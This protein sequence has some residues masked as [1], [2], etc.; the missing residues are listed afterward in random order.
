MAYSEDSVAKLAHNPLLKKGN[1]L[2][3]ID[4]ST[5]S[6]VDI[7]PAY[8]DIELGRMYDYI[9]FDDEAMIARMREEDMNDSDIAAHTFRFSAEDI[10]SAGGHHY[11][12]YRF[13]EKQVVLHPATDI[14]AVKHQ[15]AI[16][17]ND[18]QSWLSVENDFNP[19]SSQRFSMAAYHEIRHMRQFVVDKNY[20]ERSS[21]HV[22]TILKKRTRTG[23]IAALLTLLTTGTA[24]SAY[25]ILSGNREVYEQA[26]SSGASVATT[27]GVL[28]LVSVATIR[29]HAYEDYQADP[30]EV[31]ARE[32]ASGDVP[33]VV[34]LQLKPEVLKRFSAYN[35][36]RE[37]P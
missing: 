19:Q 32:A 36:T 16:N 30:N 15:L 12:S 17:K 13:D 18:I 24:A 9:G 34:T 3:S 37:T 22:R 35:T 21:E 27:L 11:G 28:A 4:P 2:V 31:D 8:A 23:R 29:R 7:L 5:V 20:S 25:N 26:I 10:Q 1:E 14:H 33:H 6:E